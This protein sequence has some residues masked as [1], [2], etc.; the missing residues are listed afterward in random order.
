[1]THKG[2]R[3]DK[4]HSRYNAVDTTCFR[5][6]QDGETIKDFIFL[7]VYLFI[8]RERGSEGEKHQCVVASCA[9]PTRDL[10]YNPGMCPD[11]ESNQ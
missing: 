6:Y 2:K 8:F 9:P 1:M 7:R 5:N 11:W 4:F 3:T 10:A